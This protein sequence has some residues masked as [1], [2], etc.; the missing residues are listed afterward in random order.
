MSLN[1]NF[2][3][4]N[5]QDNKSISDDTKLFYLLST[6]QG[7]KF[8]LILPSVLL[9]LIAIIG[10]PLNAGIIYVSVKYRNKLNSTANFLIALNAFFD[11]LQ[12]THPFPFFFVATSSTN[13]IGTF[14][15]MRLLIPALFGIQCSLTCIAFT[16]ID[17]LIA[18][19]IPIKYN[20]M[21]KRTQ[22]RYSSINVLLCTI[23][24][25]WNVVELWKKCE[26]EENRPVTGFI[27]QI[28]WDSK[29]HLGHYLVGPVLIGI[30]IFCYILICIILIVRKAIYTKKNVNNLE[31]NLFQNQLKLLKSLS[32]IV[33]VHVGTVLFGSLLLGF[34]SDF[35]AIWNWYLMNLSVCIILMGPLTNAIVLYMNSAD[36]YD[37]F[38]ILLN[39]IKTVLLKLLNL[40]LKTCRISTQI[41]IQTTKTATVN[42]QQ[43]QQMYCLSNSTRTTVRNDLGSP[44]IRVTPVKNTL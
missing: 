38:K 43:N 9:T 8:A 24:G 29:N 44:S 36:Y 26:M 27:G 2:I 15:S 5:I 41:N 42:P 7:P 30:S 3:I 16:A 10:I 34:T 6:E 4:E 13:F 19:V 37:L 35:S 40:I 1:N 20:Q 39:D 14:L 17:R 32:L 22:R 21:S 18:V 28:G 25:L 31:T 12:L 33:S 11:L 23:N